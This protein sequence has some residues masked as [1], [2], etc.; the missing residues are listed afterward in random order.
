MSPRDDYVEAQLRDRRMA[1]QFCEA[2]DAQHWPK[3]DDDSQCRDCVADERRDEHSADHEF[4]ECMRHALASVKGSKADPLSAA[5]TKLARRSPEQAA[6][7]S[8]PGAAAQ[9]LWAAL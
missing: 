1:E 7:T 6:A 9:R 5:M 8:S 2:D 3:D 4:G